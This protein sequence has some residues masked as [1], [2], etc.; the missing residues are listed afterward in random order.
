MP[1]PLGVILVPEALRQKKFDRNQPA[2]NRINARWGEFVVVPTDW[3]RSSSATASS[4]LRT[5][6]LVTSFQSIF[7]RC[8]ALRAGW[9]SIFL[10]PGLG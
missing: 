4:K 9:A 5:E 10:E 1:G 8:A 7:W 2:M 6:R 3:Q